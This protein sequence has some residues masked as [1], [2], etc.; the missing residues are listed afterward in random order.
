MLEYVNISCRS[1][2]VKDLEGSHDIVLSSRL[3]AEEEEAALCH[4]VGDNMHFCHVVRVVLYEVATQVTDDSSRTLTV[5]CHSV[6]ARCHVLTP[7]DV[8]NALININKFAV[9]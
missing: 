6:L 9:I 2:S 3:V 7:G 4:V 1:T 5:T 8:I